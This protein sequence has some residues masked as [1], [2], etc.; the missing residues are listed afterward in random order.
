MLE[1]FRTLVD[2]KQFK[3]HHDDDTA[4][5][6]NRQYS[7]ILLIVLATVVSARQYLGEAIH[8]WCPEQCATNHETYANVWCWIDDT[9]YVPFLDKMPQSEE[10]KDRKITYYQWVP[11]ILMLQA[12][13]FSFPRML[14]KLMSGRSGINVSTIIEAA[15]TSQ[16]STTSETREK[17]LRYVVHL[18][19]R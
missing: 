7:S 17:N 13:M 16:T 4:D 3:F 9:Y 14:W 10:G 1:I 15:E 8:C 12:I 18:L 11:I 2:F 6:L 19:D 5:R